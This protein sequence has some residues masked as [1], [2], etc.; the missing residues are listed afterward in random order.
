MGQVLGEILPLAIGV[1]ISVVPIIAVILMLM[2]PEARSNGLAFL[3][4]W[5]LG[6]VVVGGVVLAVASGADVATEDG[7]STAVEVAKLVFGILFLLLAL[8]Q[9]RSRPAPGAEP[10][11]PKWMNRIDRVT[12]GRAVGLGAALSG[13]NPKNLLLTASASAI[14]AQAG[15]ST[16]QEVGSL[17]I[18]VLLGSLGVLAPVGAYFALG[19]R[20][21]GV[22]GDWRV[23]LAAN[24][25][26]IMFVL[27][28]V[29]GASLIGKG[30]GGLA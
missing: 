24:N 16:G 1:A 10:S 12:P 18:F 7:P 28:L 15:L 4:G 22:L 14:V 26:A 27:F 2:T 17:A 3:A 5:L 23:W 20:A 8:K 19:S 9:W 6:L 11:L 29:F 13:V 21:A 25:A 30:I